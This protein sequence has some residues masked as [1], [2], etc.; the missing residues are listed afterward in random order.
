MEKFLLLGRKSY[1][2]I[3]KKRK[4]K[5]SPYPNKIDNKTRMKF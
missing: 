3:Y 2:K 4:G 1:K 5:K